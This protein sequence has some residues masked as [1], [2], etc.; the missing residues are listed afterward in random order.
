M[1]AVA[2]ATVVVVTEAAAT[3]GATVAGGTSTLEAIFMAEV[4]ITAFTLPISAART[5]WAADPHFPV[6]SRSETSTTR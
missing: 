2:A 4:A 3:V 1:E 6:R 5:T